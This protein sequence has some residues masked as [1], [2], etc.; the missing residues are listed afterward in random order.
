VISTSIYPIHRQVIDG[1]LILSERGFVSRLLRLIGG[2]G[3]A[4]CGGLLI[5]LPYANGWPA[6][7]RGGLI[8]AIFLI[9]T[10]VGIV[11]L[12]LCFLWWGLCD[13]F[14]WDRFVFSAQEIQAQI[15][16]G[17]F[18]VWSRTFAV[19]SFAQIHVQARQLSRYGG[20]H[21]AVT[22]AGP[23]RKLAIAALG[24]RQKAEAMVAELAARLG[25]PLAEPI[26]LPGKTL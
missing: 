21:Y 16:L 15:T 7:P 6:H 14:S 17:G 4:G 10:A 1:H 24:D 23:A 25:L 19:S 5:Y 22:C 3:F 13:I 18:P 8:G 20:P 26:T 9:I 12:G 2:T 11:A